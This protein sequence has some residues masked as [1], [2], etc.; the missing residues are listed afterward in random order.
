MKKESYHVKKTI[1]NA[2]VYS[3]ASVMGKAV[4]FIMLPVY[5]HYLRSEGYGIV[6][7]IDVVISALSLLIGYGISGAMRR[8]YFQKET[9]DQ[10]NIFVSTNI[11]LMFILVSVVTI[12]PLIFSQSIAHF[13]FGKEGFGYYLILGMIA[14]MTDTAARNAENYVLIRQQSYLYFLI[15]AG[16]LVIGLFLNIYFIVILNMGVLGFLYSSMI[17][18]TLFM[19]IN[20]VYVYYLVGFH[21]K[22]SDAIDI[23]KFSAPLLPGY[24]AMF[25]RLRTDRII[26]MKYLGLA[27]LGAYEMMLKFVSILVFVV[28][29]PL[30]NSWDVKRIEI[31]EKEEGPSY[32]SKMFT[33]HM[34]VSIFLGLVISLEIPLVLR[35][36][37]PNEFWVGSEIVAFAVLS[38][39]ALDSYYHFYF[40]LIYSKITYKVS[41]TQFVAAFLNILL[42]LFMIKYWGIMGAVITSTAVNALQAFMGY[43]MARK[44]YKIDFEWNKLSVMLCIVLIMYL[45]ASKISLEGT[46]L[47]L[48]LT[49]A[50]SEPITLLFGIVQLDRFHNGKLLLYFINNFPLLLEC[51]LKLLFSCGFILLLLMLRIVPGRISLRSEPS[52][53]SP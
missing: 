42:N 31:C 39:L 6:G 9:V 27:Q 7:M 35:L 43:I 22:K 21:F 46:T 29:D 45:A 33:Y 14:F 37:T 18:G 17:I 38:R 20:H 24:I 30:M 32:M 12:P 25:F 4:G 50:I 36:L 23:L 2:F 15:Q 40:G 11:T 19:F 52:F 10:K 8:F 51:L 53:S 49:S 5:A 41:I 28:T 34:A 47:S 1:K 48:W 26:L 13:V 3:G 44:Y 16:R